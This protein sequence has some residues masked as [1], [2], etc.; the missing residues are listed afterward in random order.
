MNDYQNVF[1]VLQ[2]SPPW[3]V[4]AQTFY[5]ALHFSNQK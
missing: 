5:K 2:K 1:T 3:W 4:S